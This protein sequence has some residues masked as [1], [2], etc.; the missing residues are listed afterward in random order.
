MSDAES[1]TKKV[2]IDKEL[3]CGYGVCA[4]ICPQVFGLDDDG[5]VVLNTDKV[6]PDLME[7]AQEAA[8]ACPQDVITFEEVEG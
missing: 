5:I 6:T 4:E 3:C 2:L 1:G 7:S 8:D